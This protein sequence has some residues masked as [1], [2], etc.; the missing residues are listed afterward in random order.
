MNFKEISKAV[1][2]YDAMQGIVL[3]QKPIHLEFSASGNNK[4]IKKGDTD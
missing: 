1:E 2:I 4:R 3:G